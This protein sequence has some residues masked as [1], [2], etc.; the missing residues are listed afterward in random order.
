VPRRVGVSA[1]V[2][3]SRSPISR[4]DVLSVREAD[5][6]GAY[7][8][9]EP[10]FEPVFRVGAG[11]AFGPEVAGICRRATEFEADEVIFL[12]VG[13]VRVGVAV[14]LLDLLGL[15]AFV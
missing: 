4:D 3:S 1:G 7:F 13:W 5:L 11:A 9:V 2:A 8:G 10:V 15:S 12:V 6:T 14:L